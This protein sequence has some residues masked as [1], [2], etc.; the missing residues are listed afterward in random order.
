MNP[1]YQQCILHVSHEDKIHVFRFVNTGIGRKGM[2]F[3]VWLDFD[4]P[5]IAL[6]YPAAGR[7]ADKKSIPLKGLPGCYYE[8]GNVNSIPLKFPTRTEAKRVADLIPN[9][10]IEKDED[11]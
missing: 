5:L 6:V 10:V 2:S 9:A 3:T 1:Y 4:K 8:I 7:K 11:F